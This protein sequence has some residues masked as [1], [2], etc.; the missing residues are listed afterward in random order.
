MG[1]SGPSNS[2]SAL[3]IP[4]PARADNKCSTVEIFAD[5]DEREVDSLV[6][7]TFSRDA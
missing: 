4:K 6:S 1:T 2:T 3:S 5:F 7:N